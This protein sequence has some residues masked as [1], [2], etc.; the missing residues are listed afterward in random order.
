MA[1]GIPTIIRSKLT[2]QENKNNMK[3][4]NKELEETNC[5]NLVVEQKNLF[6]NNR[7]LTKK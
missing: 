2:I 6:F 1:L 7:K 5:S 3:T 4:K